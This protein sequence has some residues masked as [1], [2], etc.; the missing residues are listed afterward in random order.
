MPTMTVD[1]VEVF[2]SEAERKKLIARL[3]RVEGQLRG[4]QKMVA[5][6]QECETVAQQ[7][8]AARGALDKAF[9]EMI[10]CAFKNKLGNGL[11]PEVKEGLAEVT[12]LL[13][14]YA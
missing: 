6:G 1:E 5:S 11:A 10:A 8:S 9:F 3:A 12:R 7:L 4:V 14:K 13:A 2:A